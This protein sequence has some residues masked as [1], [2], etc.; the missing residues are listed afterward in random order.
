M[1]KQRLS[2]QSAS[3]GRR[4]RAK[5]LPSKRVETRESTSLADPARGWGEENRA[6]G[7]AGKSGSTDGRENPLA[8]LNVRRL[9]REEALERLDRH[10]DQAVL[11]DLPYFRILHGKGTG[12]LK[13]A[14]Q[15]FLKKDDRVAAFREGEPV[16]GGWGVTVVKM[17]DVE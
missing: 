3:L 4:R 16:E 1:R 13:T 10:V 5:R 12:I 15:E 7:R 11:T 14:I 9:S 8:L 17:K 2:T 6:G